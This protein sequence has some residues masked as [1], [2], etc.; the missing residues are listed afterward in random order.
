MNCTCGGKVIINGGTNS[1]FCQAESQISQ[2]DGDP[3]TPPAD[4]TRPALYTNL[5]NG[6]LS[7]W[8]VT[9]QAWI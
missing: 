8:N 4:P 6:E 7:T 5:L 3:A 9:A 2:G 1:I